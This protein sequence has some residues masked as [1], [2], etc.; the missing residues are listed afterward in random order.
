MTELES[1]REFRLSSQ[2]NNGYLQTLDDEIKNDINL[3]R[4]LSGEK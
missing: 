3:I 1:S 2:S 4:D